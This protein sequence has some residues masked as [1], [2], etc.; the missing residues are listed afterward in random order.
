M[1]TSRTPPPNRASTARPAHRYS[2]MRGGLVYWVLERLLRGKQPKNLHL[3][4]A[5]LLV[6]ICMLPL[7]IATAIEGTLYGGPVDIPLLLDFSTLGRFVIAVPILVIAAPQCD[8]L[9]RRTIAHIPRCGLVAPE[10]QAAYDR[11][12]GR[13]RSLRDPKG[14]ETLLLFVAF[15][16]LLY[17]ETTFDNIPGLETWRSGPGP[18]SVFAGSW[19]DFLG[20]PVF[21]FVALLWFWRFAMWTYFLWR[22]SRLNLRFDAGHPDGSAGTL[23]LGESQF[24]F[25]VL[26]F[27]GGILVSGSCI[28][29]VMYLGETIDHQKHIIIGYILLSVGVLLMPLLLLG[30]RLFSVKQKAL[31]AYSE[32]GHFAAND[33][34]S[35][36][37]TERSS[38]ALLDSGDSSSLADYGTVYATVRGMSIFP[39]TRATVLWFFLVTALPFLPLF[40]IAMPLEELMDRLVSVIA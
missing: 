19:L 14:P 12:L 3:W 4:L 16:P 13:I 32:L 6:V 22:L 26:A 37:L 25:S 24:R 5:L 21:R 30:R 36:W 1:T 20:L 35:R 18:L 40:L 10:K 33:F 39:M 34:G 11:L 28:N 38:K 23:F 27:A 15:A 29:H 8:R 7:V 2:L 9:L 17:M 31:L